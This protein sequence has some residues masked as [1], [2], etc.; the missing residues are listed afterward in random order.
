MLEGK[1]PPGWSIAEHDITIEFWVRSEAQMMEILHDPDFQALL[2]EEGDMVDA[3]RAEL[4][5]GWE[6]VY[7]ED[8]KVVNVADG[9]SEYP[10]FTKSV[11]L[12]V[13]AGKKDT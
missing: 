13:A 6:E 8:G 5:V 9:K 3:E 4:T 12:A 2:A 1:L 11:E 10:P 7:V